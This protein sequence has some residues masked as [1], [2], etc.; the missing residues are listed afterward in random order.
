MHCITPC[1][2]CLVNK[3]KNLESINGL[4]VCTQLTSTLKKL[5]HPRTGDRGTLASPPDPR[6]GRQVFWLSDHSTCRTFPPRFSETVVCLRL[7]SPITAAGP[8][9][10]YTGFPIKPRW[11]PSRY[12]TH[13]NKDQQNPSRANAIKRFPIFSG[14]QIKPN[15]KWEAAKPRAKD[16]N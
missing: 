12:D 8:L 2:G 15:A 1:F 9:P 10:L 5:Q 13:T 3:R 4:K 6:S 14:R 16:N 7:S 11:V